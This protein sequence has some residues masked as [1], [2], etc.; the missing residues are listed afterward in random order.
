MFHFIRTS[1]DW[2]KSYRNIS[3]SPL[4]SQPFAPYPNIPPLWCDF[5]ELYSDLHP[6]QVK[7]WPCCCNM[8]IWNLHMSILDSMWC[9]CWHVTHG[10]GWPSCQKISSLALTVWELWYFEDLEE[11]DRLL[12]E[13]MNDEGVYRT[14]PATPGLLN[15]FTAPPRPHCSRLSFES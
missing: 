2:F 8:C 11:E 15:I 6:A 10:I 14:A 5:S 3:S 9:F 4:L 1:H 12:T 7:V 13:L